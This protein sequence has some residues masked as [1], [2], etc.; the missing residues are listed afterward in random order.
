MGLRETHLRRFVFR[1]S[2]EEAWEVYGY[3][4]V[5]FGDRPAALAL[6]LG[7][8]M[9]ANNAKQLDPQA[10]RQLMRNSLVD[11]IGGGGTEEEV[12]RMRGEKRDGA[13]TGTLPRVL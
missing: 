8:E 7:K 9:A 5:A 11:D 4:V 6:E 12:D 13:Y 2:K 10:A 3:L 1:F